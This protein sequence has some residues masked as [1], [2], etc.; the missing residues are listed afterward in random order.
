MK[1]RKRLFAAAGFNTTY[2][3]P[4]R[5]EFDPKKAM[6]TFDQY[7][8]E[9]AM[10]T[11]ALVKNCDFDQG[12]IG[13]F[14][15]ARFLNQANI[16]G[17]M[18]L[19]VPHLLAKPCT[20]VEGACGTGGRA[21][22]SA[23]NIILSDQADAVFVA[24]FEVQNVVK[25]VYGADILAGA[26][27]YAKERKDG[28]A[29]FFPGVFS[30]R[31]EKYY[32]KYG[33]DDTRIGMAKWYENAILNARKNPKAQEYH[34]KAEDL[35]SLGM[36]KPDAK[37]FVQALNL[38][39]C[40]KVSDGAS[41]ILIL[42]EEGLKKCGINRQ[43]AV[44]IVAVVG[45]QGDITEQPK[46]LCK[47]DMTETAGKKA[48]LD[49]GIDLSDLSVLELH[50]CFTIT[51]LLALEALG[52]AKEGQSSKFVQDG[53]IGKKFSCNTIASCRK[54]CGINWDKQKVYESCQHSAKPVYCRFTCQ[55]A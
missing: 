18:P 8:K 22:A 45:A 12:V 55:F 7:L 46:D 53:N 37:K 20:G 27:Y 26:A 13:S 31:A 2:L 19:M 17:F 49:A 10:G 6:P 24:G 5:N 48:L 40:S 9:T 47:L 3:G 34:N 21:I 4:G 16:S 39:D 30:K 50:D 1:L 38:Y 15:S 32:D 54:H 52:F 42:S 44:E 43:D 41:S 11:T 25:A 33:Y 23:A 36:T 35:F 29:F 51:G 28:E 14:M